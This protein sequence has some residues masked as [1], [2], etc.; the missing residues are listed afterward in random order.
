MYLCIC[1]EGGLCGPNGLQSAQGIKDLALPC[2]PVVAALCRVPVKFAPVEVAAVCLFVRIVV[3][4]IVI[5]LSHLVTAVQHGNTALGQHPGVEHD[6]AVQCP[7]LL[8]EAGLFHAAERGGGAAEPG[9]AQ[10][11]VVVI[12][13][14]PGPASRP[15][16]GEPVVEIFFV[17]NLLY[18]KLTQP[19]V[20]Q[21]PANVVV[22]AEII[23]EQIVPGK[24][25]DLLQLAFQQPDVSGG[26][27][28]P[29]GAH[30]GHIVQD[31]TLRLF[32]STE[33]GGHLRRLHHHLAQQQH[34]GA[35][36]LTGQMQH[37][38]QRVYL[39]QI[40]AVGAQLFPDIGDGVQTDDVHTP[41]GEV[42]QVLRHVVKDHGV[43]V[44]QVPLIG[45]EGGHDHLSAVLQP[46]KAARGGGGED[47]GHRLLKLVGNIPVVVKEIAVS[48][49]GIPCPGGLRPGM[50]LAGVIH[51]KVQTQADAFAVTGV[52]QCLQILHGAQLRLH[53]PEVRHGIAA[54]AAALHCFQQRH[55]MEVVD[56]A[57]LQIGEL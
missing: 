9:V 7:L 17:G 19:G 6:I 15:L 22:T 44:V 50:I 23:L 32:L 21:S 34:A 5:Q 40:A 41:V 16:A 13:L 29:G 12:Q 26:H 37:P 38:C 52:R 3:I 10:F 53:C 11:G 55:Q 31:V 33:V 47:L 43:C 35:D 57:L 1:T 8:F 4:G 49:D 36:Y 24:S 39:G 14:A 2:P 20:V 42:E 25:A 46:G 54:V 51:H 48:G 28:V 45:I 18:G 30:G 56:A 27:G